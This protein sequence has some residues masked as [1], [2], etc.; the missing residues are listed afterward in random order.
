MD[1]IPIRGTREWAVAEI[2][3]CTGCSHGCRYCYARYDAV[4][5]KKLLTDAEWSCCRVE[6]ALLNT[7]HPLYSGQVMFPS[8]H[9]ILPENLE[10]CI[11]L[12]RKLLD[13][14]NRVLIVSKPHY[15]CIETLCRILVRYREQI[16][17]RFTIT[18]R[19]KQPLHFWEPN[20]PDFAERKASL[21]H[22]FA[23][24]FR[25]SVSIEPMLDTEDVVAMVNE[26]LPYASHSIWLGK[27]NKVRERV[28]I[29][30]EEVALAV[31]AIEEGQADEKIWR[32]Y[33]ELC[34]TPQI[35]WKESIRQVVG[36]AEALE[37]GL[38]W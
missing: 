1:R 24:G 21:A 3:C 19:D 28:T 9:D 7:A 20:A 10:A 27:M 35:R 32:I 13:L 38:D 29:D 30:C 8:R 4:E 22:V 16:L 6:P 36:L 12:L 37:P 17:F 15:S 23:H 31:K 33:R 34:T 18:A 11:A 14:G 2:N 5:R 25:T 26:L